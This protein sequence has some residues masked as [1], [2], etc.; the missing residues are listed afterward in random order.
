M[1]QG[2]QNLKRTWLRNNSN[3]D[4]KTKLEK[5]INKLKKPGKTYTKAQILAL[6]RK[7][8]DKSISQVKAENE[9]SMRKNASARNAAFKAAQ[10]L[11]IKNKKNKK[12]TVKEKEKFLGLAPYIHKKFFMK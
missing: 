7:A 6:K 10:K 3:K 1:G 5:N 4:K 9:A 8:Q 12:N 2:N 11:K